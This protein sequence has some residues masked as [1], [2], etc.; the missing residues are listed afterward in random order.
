MTIEYKD[1]KRIVALSSDVLN[2]PT[3]EDDFSTD[4]WVDTGSNI[5]VN[6]ST[7]VIDWNGGQS[8]V[9]NGTSYDLT[10][11]SD[12]AWV[13]RY[14]MVVDNLTQG[15]DSTPDNLMIGISASP[16]STTASTSQNNIGVKFNVASGSK[17]IATVAG[18]GN[19]FTPIDTFTTTITS[20][21]YYTEIKRN[22]STS[23]TVSLYSDSDYSTL[24]ESKT[25]TISG[26]PTGLQY[27]KVQS[28]DN[29]D[30]TDN[31]TFD[32]TIDDIEFY[33][34]V[35][36]LTNKP[37]NVQDNSLLVEKDT[38]RRYWF[39]EALAPTLEDDFSSSTGWTT[40]GSGLSITG[41]E[42]DANFTGSSDN[43]I[44]KDLGF[45]LENKFISHFDY[46][47]G[48][49]SSGYWGMFSFTSGTSKPFTSSQ[50]QIGAIINLSGYN[51]LAR[52]YDGSSENTSQSGTI[53]LSA[54]TQ[55]YVTAIRDGTSF[56]IKVYSDSARTTQVGSTISQTLSTDVS[57]SLRYFQ[58]GHYI[59]GSGTPI[60]QIDN[61]KIYNGVTSITPATW[62]MQ[63]DWTDDFSSDNWTNIEGTN[64]GVSGGV[65]AYNA[66]AGAGDDGAYRDY[67]S[68]VSETFVWRFTWNATNISKGSHSA[69]NEVNFGISSNTLDNGSNN[70]AVGILLRVD[71][72]NKQLNAGIWK[73]DPPD[74]TAPVNT[75]L[76]PSTFAD[77]VYYVEI[78]R[79]SNRVFTITLYSDSSFSTSAY[80]TTLTNNSDLDDLRYFKVTTDHETSADSVNNGSL[81]NFE[82]YNGVT[83]IN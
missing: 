1:S 66:G 32:G 65:L 55:Y 40:V 34:G 60:Y 61:L 53:S 19:T 46:Y 42:L 14:K 77:G 49:V 64:V 56:E 38:A 9:N 73:N 44:Y 45:N 80:T 37:T 67:G 22:S 12:T 21:T 63:S 5:E 16:S 54:N 72:N 41:G 23:M 33:N 74:S 24:I 4:D 79:Q 6:T 69:N 70:D 28:R 58:T 25:S 26:S 17:S 20:T 75:A 27:L 43:R 57:L 76:E 18:T 51:V 30:G 3:F 8:N 62:T 47:Q 2:T 11:V 10:T 29:L 81:D 83:S 15:G 82:F 39:S 31:H 52:S 71:S 36:S 7:D 68:V 35:S 48:T 59:G 13:L 50:D 78:V